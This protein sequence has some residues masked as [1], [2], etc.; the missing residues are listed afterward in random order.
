MVISEMIG[1]LRSI[2]F[3]IDVYVRIIFPSSS[4]LRCRPCSFRFEML[5]Q[6]MQRCRICADTQRALSIRVQQGQVPT[7]N[8]RTCGN[9]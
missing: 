8:Y 2:Q 5:R 3:K 9:G 1:L 4:D 6:V 7:Y